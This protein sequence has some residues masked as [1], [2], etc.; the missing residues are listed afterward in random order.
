VTHNTVMRVC[1]ITGFITRLLVLYA[2]SY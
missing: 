2:S 1:Y